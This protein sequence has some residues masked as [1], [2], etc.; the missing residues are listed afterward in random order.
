LV[1]FSGLPLD[2]KESTLQKM[3]IYLALEKIIQSSPNL[4]KVP[5][6]ILKVLGPVKLKTI[7]D[8]PLILKQLNILLDIKKVVNAF[9][10]AD[11]GDLDE[12]LTNVDT[13][14]EARNYYV[15]KDFNGKIKLW[16]ELWNIKFSNCDPNLQSLI[17]IKMER[18]RQDA[19]KYTGG[20]LTQN[21]NKRLLE[22]YLNL[23]EDNTYAEYISSV[24]NLPL[25]VKVVMGI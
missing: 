1:Q 2:L 4:S 11:I 12:A 24:Q 13:E 23:T 20:K 16:V 17:R 25:G 21:E 8:T 18:F 22:S 9:D 19:I 7:I 15:R 6:L 10:D 3:S 5:K 14:S